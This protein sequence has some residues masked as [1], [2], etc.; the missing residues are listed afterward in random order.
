MKCPHEIALSADCRECENSETPRTRTIQCLSSL[1]NLYAFLRRNAMSGD[2]VN[3]AEQ[4]IAALANQVIGLQAR[5]DYVRKQPAPRSPMEQLVSKYHAI[6]AGHFDRIA[7]L[8]GVEGDPLDESVARIVKERD[9]LRA[10]LVVRDARISACEPVVEAVRDW[11]S[12]GC[13]VG[14]CEHA[15]RAYNSVLPLKE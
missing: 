4:T 3:Q 14:V 7:Q 11:Q 15:I 1:S 13:G 10:Q 5:L 6:K 8:C 9:A 12:C 2:A